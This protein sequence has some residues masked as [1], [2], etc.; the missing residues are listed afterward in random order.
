PQCRAFAWLSA[1]RRPAPAKRA[2]SRLAGTRAQG[3]RKD[4]RARIPKGCVCPGLSRRRRQGCSSMLETFILRWGYAAVAVGTFLEGEIVLIA[5][6]A[7]AHRG[8]LS[9]PFVVL[10]AFLGSVAGDQLW[11]YVGK[12]AGR[13]FVTRRPR[14]RE[15]AHKAER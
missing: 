7:L 6:G 3:R 5:G 12:R 4:A 13:S 10:A 14:L 8:L 9:L 2:L 1:W 15:H 11:F